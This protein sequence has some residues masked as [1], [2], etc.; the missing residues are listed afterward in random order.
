M[1]RARFYEAYLCIF[2]SV[3]GFF[4]K[5]TGKE[6]SL[7]S[8]PKYT[9]GQ[10]RHVT[11]VTSN[12]PHPSICCIQDTGEHEA[13]AIPE[14]RVARQPRQKVRV[15]RSRILESALKVFS[16]ASVAKNVLEFEFFNE[17]GTGLGPTLEFYTLLA[18]D[19][20]KKSLGMWRDHS[21]PNNSASKSEGMVPAT[22]ALLLIPEWH[23]F[24]AFRLVCFV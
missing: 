23:I 22:I 8:K 9:S 11:H 3:Q 13:Q 21:M 24:K 20:Q 7:S 6:I 15:S 16:M 17:I 10:D 2:T 14:M 18:A 12:G 4:L 1:Y 19:L 5:F